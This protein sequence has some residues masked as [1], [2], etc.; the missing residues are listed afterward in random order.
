MKRMSVKMGGSVKDEEEEPSRMT[1]GKGEGVREA[2]KQRNRRK[3][4]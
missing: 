2:E 3:R 4:R 1:E